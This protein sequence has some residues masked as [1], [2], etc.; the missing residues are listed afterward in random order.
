MEVLSLDSR[1]ILGPIAE[2]TYTHAFKTSYE[3][4]S[5]LYH[6]KLS[7]FLHNFF[8]L[9]LDSVILFVFCVSWRVFRM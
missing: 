2:N 6:N 3:S 1:Y 7:Y 8:A 9:D 5:E 4:V